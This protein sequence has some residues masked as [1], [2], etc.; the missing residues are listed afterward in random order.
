MQV[1]YGVAID[2]AVQNDADDLSTLYAATWLNSIDASVRYVSTRLEVGNDGP[3]TIFES[4]AGAADG[5]SQFSES[6]FSNTV[7]I[8]KKTGLGGRQYRGRLYMV[9]MVSDTNVDGSG[10]LDGTYRNSVQTIANAW[11]AAL[12]GGNPGPMVL[13]HADDGVEPTPVTQLLVRQRI[14]TQRRRIK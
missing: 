10:N 1:T 13:L 2:G 7:L 9:G 11:L 6:P 14:G 3:P 5:G 8:S 12:N 4:S